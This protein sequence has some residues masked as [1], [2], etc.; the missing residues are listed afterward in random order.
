MNM[1]YD[2]SHNMYSKNQNKIADASATTFSEIVG[3]SKEAIFEA[4]SAVG[5]V[6]DDDGILNIGVSFDGSWQRRGHSSHNGVACVID[7]L[8]GL[9]IDY[10][11]LSN[12]CLKCQLASENPP[13]PGDYEEWKQNHSPNCPKNFNGSANA[14]EVE[15][16]LRLWK[17]SVADH[18]LRYTAMLCDGDSKSFDAVCEAKVYGKV[19]I[20]KEDCINHISKRMGTALRKLSA[21]SKSQGASISGK[22][23]LTQAKILKIQNYYGRAIKDHADDVDLLKKRLMA[24]LFHLSSTDENP[25]HHHCPSGENSWCFWQR[26][27]AKDVEPGSHKDHETVPTDIGKRMVPIFQRLSDTSLLK[28][29]SRQGTQNPNESLHN[30]IWRLCPNINFAGRKT[31]ETDVLLSLCQF[32]MGATFKELLC[33]VLGIMPGEYLRDGTRKK[34][35]RRLSKAELANT[36]VAK[37][38]RKQWKYKK[39][40]QEQKTKTSEGQTYASGQFNE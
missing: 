39:T 1:P 17:R 38:R 33:R 8:T 26:A 23:K 37:K 24:I 5:V 18:K 12:F 25:K 27:L 3:K 13:A 35:L 22:G 40:S 36:Q 30:L 20:C 32:S 16:A 7:L 2:I 14:M 21:E 19:K 34:T 9:P 15:A 6:P 4:Y 10:E 29:C 28:R 31:V 11:V